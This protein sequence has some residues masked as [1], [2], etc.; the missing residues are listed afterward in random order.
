MID[1]RIMKLTVFTQF[2]YR[3]FIGTICF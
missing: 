3:E 2:G 1:M